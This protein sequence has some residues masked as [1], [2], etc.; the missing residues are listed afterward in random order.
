MKKRDIQKL[1]AQYPKIVEWSEED[2]CFVGRC[3]T[4]FSGGVHGAAEAS[5][6]RELCEAA[7]EWVTILQSEGVPLPESKR[8]GDYSGKFLVRVDPALHQR[9]ALR[10]AAAGESLNTWVART[11]TKMNR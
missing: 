8:S 2:D 1:A 7:E 5:V 9:L 10:A 6:Y 11:L 3:P 4:L